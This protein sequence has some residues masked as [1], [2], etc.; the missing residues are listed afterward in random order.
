M[1]NSESNDVSCIFFGERMMA[2]KIEIIRAAIYQTIESKG[3][4]KKIHE[5]MVKLLMVAEQKLMNEF[6]GKS[7]KFQ[8]VA[9]LQKEN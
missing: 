6:L 9:D 4:L 7:W 3:E 5:D 1:F 2:S 8:S